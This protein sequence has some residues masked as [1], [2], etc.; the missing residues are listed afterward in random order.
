MERGR[1]RDQ[2]MER[3]EAGGSDGKREAERS[4]DG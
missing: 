1:Q 2:I 3:H 4:D